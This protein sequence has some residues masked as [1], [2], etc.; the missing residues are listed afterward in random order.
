MEQRVQLT[1][2]AAGEPSFSAVELRIGAI[3]HRRAN[4]QLLGVPWPRFQKAYEEY[5]RWQALAL[6]VQAV[7]AAGDSVPSWLTDD[8][9][10]HCPGFLATQ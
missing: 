8:L 5:P 10:K 6:W 7:I 1:T 4:E 9:R 2:H 3:A